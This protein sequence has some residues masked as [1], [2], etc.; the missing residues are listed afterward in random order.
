MLRKDAS[1]AVIGGGIVG[2]HS[3]LELANAGY[4]V[5]LVEKQPALGGMVARLENIFPTNDCSS[6][7]LSTRLMECSRHP[8]I[9]ILTQTEVMDLEG[10]EGNMRMH[11]RKHPSFID[12]DKCIACNKCSEVCL[13]SAPDSFNLGLKPRRAAYVL[14]NLSIP[15]RYVI[16][17]DNCLRLT[18]GIC[19]ACAKACPTGAIDFND[20]EQG[21]ELRVNSV[22]LAPGLQQVDLQNSD[23]YGYKEI[24]DVV[25]SLEYERLLSASGPGQGLLKRPSD[26]AEPASVAWLQCVGSRTRDAGSNRSCS[27][28]CCMYAIKQAMVSGNHVSRRRL[29]CTIF[30]NDIRAQGKA[31]E[32]FYDRAIN[33]GVRFIG[34]R[35]HTMSPGE[36]G[37]G[38]V[39]SYFSGNAGLVQKH[40]DLLV[41]STGFLPE[42]SSIDLAARLGIK[43]SR[44]RFAV[45][46][47]FSPF[48]SNRPGV[49]LAGSVCAP[50]DI[51]QSIIDA[52]GAAS[53]ATQSIPGKS[54]Q[55]STNPFPREKNISGQAIRAGVFIC[56]CGGNISD[57]I[58][59]QDLAEFAASIPDV[60][61]VDTNLFTC[62]RIT[63]DK[64]IR[65]IQENDL[66]RV[67]IAACTP[68]T[69]EP[70][71]RDT[72]QSAGLNQYLLEIANIRNHNSWVHKDNP[73]QATEKARMQISAAVSR[74]RMN[75]P[76]L[77]LPKKVIPKAM[78][79]G[80]GLTGMTAALELAGQGIETFLVEKSDH[81]GGNAWNLRT[82][83]KGED[84]S[85][86]LD[87]LISRVENNPRIHLLKRAE[88]L[89]FRG[90][91]GNFISQV[92]M[93]R[94][95]GANVLETIRYGTAIFCTG[96]LEHKPAEHLH[97]RDERV[98]TQNEFD[99]LLKS[100]PD[101]IKSAGAVAFIQCVGSR[102]TQHK[103]CSRVCC[104]RSIETALHLKRHNPS[105]NVYVLYRDIRTYGSR[106][107]LY[108]EARRQGVIFIR[109]SRTSKPEVSARDDCL[110]IKTTD[111][112]L[113]SPL[114]I[115]A[116]YLVLAAAIVP[117][118]GNQELARKLKCSRDS[119]GFA[120]EEH[121][122]L[123][124]ADLSCSGVFAAGLCNAPMPMEEAV[125]QARA[126]VSRARQILLK[127]SI[128]LDPVKAGIT[129]NCDACG[130]CVDKCPYEAIHLQDI[131]GTDQ[132]PIQRVCIEKA[133]CQGCG[134][135][136]NY[137]SRGGIVLGEYQEEKILAQAQAL[138]ETRRNQTLKHT[139][140]VMVFCC[141]WGSYQAAD[142]AGVLKRRYSPGAVIIRVNCVGILHEDTLLK[143]MQ[144][145]VDG[146]MV[147]GCSK[148]EC[149]HWYGDYHAAKRLPLVKS[150]MKNLGINP[151]RIMSGWISSGD[152]L[153][154][155]QMINTFTKQ[156]EKL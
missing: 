3:A 121:Y 138:L 27:S 96:A 155:V 67:V 131:P 14:H 113:E 20:Q 15:S 146:I 49:Y 103:Y 154:L 156:L 127:D 24:P 56:S 119:H 71:Y 1:V 33:Q 92:H 68:R 83:W 35:P 86:H 93:C 50:R 16:D 101:K 10:P 144:M 61:L 25:T 69:H 137:C 75:K 57:I 100:S 4:S 47:S 31:D 9:E 51:R 72:L 142:A 46:S 70:L 84:V 126:A 136:L 45:T 58:D 34:E 139:P 7:L 21:M 63:Q 18:R 132:D 64:I 148:G 52:G 90:S 99:R 11:L 106:E 85:E 89:S 118:P 108:E 102:D 116:N 66:N 23:T 130:A 22:I 88:I 29:D 123:Q 97:G 133:A 104:T 87:Q 43:L 91:M 115:H 40:Y 95:D 36:N 30:F 77:P 53:T 6:C 143:L 19:G 5:C 147:I 42:K 59:V 82:T 80:A 140:L 152:S 81:P 128:H 12:P 78:V 150:R 124:P 117:D 38:V 114:E 74:V 76:M 55:T 13:K 73:R 153:K 141:N 54:L 129:E 60:V 151:E 149:R 48:H 111:H 28:I 8:G 44:D 37:R 32:K 41:L 17:P 120:L 39:T 2:V 125:A 26:G 94:H 105:L 107:L 134:I 145:G 135:C 122:F 79:V 110:K 62:P 65:L 98:Y 109:H 112:I